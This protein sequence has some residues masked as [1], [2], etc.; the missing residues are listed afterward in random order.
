MKFNNDNNKKENDYLIQTLCD[1]IW[2]I[3]EIGVFKLSDYINLKKLEK[4]L[5]L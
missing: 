4:R 3:V 2:F 1:C 5:K